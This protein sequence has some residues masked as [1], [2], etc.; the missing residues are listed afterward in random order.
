MSEVKKIVRDVKKNIERI[1][2]ELSF[3]FSDNFFNLHFLPNRYL[4][5]YN[6]VVG[7]PEKRYIKYGK[8]LK[9]RLKNF[10]KF[11]SSRDFK[12][13]LKEFHATVFSKGLLEKYPEGKFKEL[14]ELKKLIAP[15]SQFTVLIKFPS[16]KQIETFKL[17]L[18]HEWLHVLLLKNN[19]SFQKRGKSWEWDEGLVTYLENYFVY[20]EKVEEK[21][22]K[23]LKAAKNE[24]LKKYLKF[25]LKWAKILK[26]KKRLKIKEEIFKQLE[27]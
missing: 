26:G 14:D 1:A 23:Y 16:Q 25:G 11:I 17:A 12:A 13:E 27:G 9:S 3:K 4:I 8:N 5:I 22:R 20:R 7:C 24:F 6:Y 21:L 2:K 10:K 18:F 19:I 15:I